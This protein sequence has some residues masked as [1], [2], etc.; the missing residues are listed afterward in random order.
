MGKTHLAWGLAF[1]SV[2]LTLLMWPTPGIH[3]R[4]KRENGHERE[5]KSMNCLFVNC[6]RGPNR[7]QGAWCVPDAE[8]REKTLEN[9]RELELNRELK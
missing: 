9:A 6:R 7:E 2:K 1:S 8:L 3:V 4:I 5:S